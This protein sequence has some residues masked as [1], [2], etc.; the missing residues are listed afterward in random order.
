MNK[1]TTKRID[2]LLIVMEKRYPGP[3]KAKHIAD[4]CGCD[5]MVI[6]KAEESALRKLKAVMEESGISWELEKY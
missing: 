1:E 2:N 3:H 6:Q 4:F 5:F